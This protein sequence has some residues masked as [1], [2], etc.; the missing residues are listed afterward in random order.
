MDATTEFSADRNRAASQEAAQNAQREA[1]NDLRTVMSSPQG[2]RFIWRM[3]DRH[4]MW[5][6]SFVENRE[7]TDFREGMRNTALMLWS[8]L[9]RVCPELLLRMQEEH[10]YV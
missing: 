8:D 2:R 10:K 7:G 5:R 1:D 6:A 4:G 9:Q 3:I